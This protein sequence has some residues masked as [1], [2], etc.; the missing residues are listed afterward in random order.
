MHA[1]VIQTF[2]G[3]DDGLVRKIEQKL[4]V[5]RILIRPIHKLCLIATYDELNSNDRVFV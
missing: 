2:P 4:Y 3:G 1:V 5:Q